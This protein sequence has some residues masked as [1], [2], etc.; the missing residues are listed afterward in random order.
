MLL[1]G[2]L[3][4]ALPGIV[5]RRAALDHHA[6]DVIM[7]VLLGTA[8]FA[9]I[10]LVR[11]GQSM[12]AAFE[13]GS[14]I[15]RD[16]IA[17]ADY[18][19][20]TGLANRR[21]LIQ[22]TEQGVIGNDLEEISVLAIDLD[23][24]KPINDTHGHGAGD[25]VLQTVAKR[26][27]DLTA[28]L[29]MAGRLGGDEF[30]CVLT[31]PKGSA[32]PIELAEDLVKAIA[33]PIPL[34]S[35]LV[36]IGA[37]IGVATFPSGACSAE[38]IFRSADFAMYRAKQA[39]RS[40]YRLFIPEMEVD[41]REQA[42]LEIDM[43][44]GIHRGEFIPFYQPIIDLASGEIVGFECLARWQHPVRG[45]IGPKLFIPIAEEAGLIHDLSFS[46]LRRACADARNWPQH[47]SLS[48][49]I[50]PL[51]LNDQW[52][53]QR[54][55]QILCQTGIAPGRLIVE[56]TESRLVGDVDAARSLL[57]SLRNAGIQ[58]ALDDFGTGYA[59]LRHL[60]ELE[61]NRIKID[62]S[63][64]QEM[65][66]AE[67]DE[68]VRAILNLSHGLGLPVTAEGVETQGNASALAHLGCTFGQGF[69]YSR[70][71]PAAEALLVARGPR[72]GAPE[73]M[74]KNIEFEPAGRVA[75][76]RR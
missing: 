21:A 40:T 54:I 45:L 26:L 6:L 48:V 3:M 11:R 55:I 31:H 68:I 47:M 59:S 72:L 62:R 2:A 27:R 14:R 74:G 12:R 63:F 39:G 44:A 56:I 65:G 9:I 35:A 15:G 36:E 57:L 38:R 7:V 5:A 70:P 24:F 60:R 18:D 33:R 52:L 1:V 50:S 41:L 10:G 69:L 19:E 32:R 64:I 76:T 29:G 46:L 66:S 22:A 67:S 28:G 73:A 61:V 75:A 4:D 71:I 13:R 58:I 37:S 16:A 49:N 23:R 51:Q 43:R 20:L 8:S 17:R 30:A 25:L 53:P 42:A 34:R